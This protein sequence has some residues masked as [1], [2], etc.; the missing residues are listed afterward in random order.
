MPFRCDYTVVFPIVSP[1]I[2]MVI[3]VMIM[4]TVL[5][6]YAEVEDNPGIWAVKEYE[7]LLMCSVYH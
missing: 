3:L 7:Y 1:V 5:P 4:P 6:M 2:V